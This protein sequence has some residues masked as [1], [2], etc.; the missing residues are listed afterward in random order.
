MFRALLVI[1]LHTALSWPCA[2]GA[3]AQESQKQPAPPLL[4][5]QSIAFARL[6]VTKIDPDALEEFLSRATSELKLHQFVANLADRN[7]RHLA[8]RLRRLKELKVEQIYVALTLYDIHA[9]LDL[10]AK[11]PEEFI[12]AIVPVPYGIDSAS[13]A[14]ALVDDPPTSNTTRTSKDSAGNILTQPGAGPPESTWLALHFHSAIQ[15]PEKGR[16]NVVLAGTPQVL[17]HLVKTTREKRLAAAAALAAAGDGPVQLAIAPSAVFSRAAEEILTSTQLGDLSIGMT[18]ADGFQWAAWGLAQQDGEIATR[19]VVQARSPEGARQ[20]QKLIELALAAAAD[21]RPDSKAVQP[22]AGLAQLARLLDFE[23]D[24]NRVQWR[25]DRQHTAKMAEALRP[26]LIS[27]QGQLGLRK[28]VDN[29]RAIGLAVANF[30]AA[31][32][33]Y[34]TPATYDKAGRPLLSWRVHVLAY[35]PYAAENQLYHEFHLNEPWDSEH[36]KKLIERMPSIY[37]R[38]FANANSAKTPYQVP[39]GEKTAFRPGI[40]MELR[41]IKDGTSKTIAIVEVDPEHEVIWTKPDDWEVDWNDPTKGL[42]GGPG[43][44]FIACFLDTAVCSIPKSID[45]EVLRRFLMADDGYPVH[46]PEVYA[47]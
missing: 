16:G 33:A 19:M 42:A 22:P 8:T 5:P 20:M 43:T 15:I 47:E 1:A 9:Q 30:Y 25:I 40:K 13:V 45:K 3:I 24:G 7:I 37:R 26:I 12:Y 34:P 29:I 36:N 35:M 23:V 4:D 38:P 18:L 2:D 44:A 21:E 46:R 11:A 6:D 31:H 32:R 27:Q 28:S 14:K 10:L 41:D 39:I 17:E